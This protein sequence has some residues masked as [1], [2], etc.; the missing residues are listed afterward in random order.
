MELDYQRRRCKPTRQDSIKN[1][2]I[3]VEMGIAVDVMET[4]EVEM[5]NWVGHVKRMS[6]ARWLKEIWE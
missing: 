5:L 1:V 2:D 4:I 3:R 6:R